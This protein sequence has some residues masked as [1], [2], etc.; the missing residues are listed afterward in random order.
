[1][2]RF[3]KYLWTP[4]LLASVTGCATS[5][6]LAD[7]KNTD[8]Q[9]TRL[10]RL[11]TIASDCEN[12]GRPDEAMNVYQYVLAQ[13]PEHAFA[14]QR[15]QVLA[16]TAAPAATPTAPAQQLPATTPVTP[17][18]PEVMVAARPTP[19]SNQTHASAA[20][21]HAIRPAAPAVTESAPLVAASSWKPTM[22]TSDPVPLSQATQ[23]QAVAQKTATQ[24][25]VVQSTVAQSHVLEKRSVKPPARQSPV[26]APAQESPIPEHPVLLTTAASEL[27]AVPV[28]NVSPVVTPSREELPEPIIS[29]T[30]LPF[31][32]ARASELPTVAAVAAEIPSISMEPAIQ[33]VSRMEF[34]PEQ[35][36][37]QPV[38]SQPTLAAPAPSVSTTSS[39]SDIFGKKPAA[40]RNSEIPTLSRSRNPIP[41]LELYLG[42]KRVSDTP[43]GTPASTTDDAQVAG[44]PVPPVRKSKVI[45]IPARSA[46]AVVAEPEVAV[47]EEPVHHPI[48]TPLQENPQKS[49]FAPEVATL[50][51]PV[52]EQS[53]VDLTV[54]ATTPVAPV[55]APKT[56]SDAWQATDLSRVT[57]APAVPANDPPAPRNDWS[58]ARLTSLCDGL[59]DDL[60]PLVEQMESKDPLTRVQALMSLSARGFEAKPASVAIHALLE[61]EEP[62]VA[63]YAAS[64]LRLV[65][66]DAWSS[67]RTLCQYLNHNDQ[68]IVRLSAYLLGLMGPEAMDAVPV[69]EVVRD[70]NPDLMSSLHAAEALTH[71]APADR[72][73][74][75]TLSNALFHA[76]GDVRWFAAVSLGSV[77]APCEQEAV[78]VLMKALR[79]SDFG[80]QAAA[81]LSLG[82]FGK[83]AQV[84]I[85]E[86]ENAARSRSSEVQ[87]AAETALAC[88]RGA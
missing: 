30:P 68:Q 67:V 61:D 55:I 40:S 9:Q 7:S 64:T 48:I 20:P 81:C 11:L 84:A 60:V 76:D 77:S 2:R 23:E 17:A 62:V 36:V 80:V 15:L 73:S 59:P 79:D 42:G 51:K 6:F 29:T 70:T 43:S 35:P 3:Q 83:H 39:N 14:R 16:G 69:L 19:S 8:A 52:D 54:T 45:E 10:N 26:S 87:E 25:T 65:A 86:L 31:P 33:P 28:M 74:L 1:M 12:S 72:R 27:P 32:D 49:L 78:T 63:V 22:M 44:E 21:N 82:G 57:Q 34:K 5:G 46:P 50:E 38:A 88:L 13:N 71:I 53:T 18:R 4:L 24:T 58:Q 47:V 41:N 56:D 75:A 85:P 66:N 37:P